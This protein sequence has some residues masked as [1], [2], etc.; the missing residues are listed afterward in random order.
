LLLAGIAAAFATTPGR[1]GGTGHDSEAGASLSAPVWWHRA[2]QTR[3]DAL[4]YWTRARMARAAPRSLTVAGPRRP[5]GPGGVDRGRAKTIPPT[6]PQPTSSVGNHALGRL[7]LAARDLISFTAYFWS[8]PEDRPPASTSGKILAKDQSG[9]YLCSGTVVT[10]A[11]RSLVWTAG[12]CLYTKQ[13]G[14]AK[15]VLFM[16]GYGGDRA[17]FGTWS[18]RGIAVTPRWRKSEAP[19]YDLGAVV[20]RRLK[21]SRIEGR[22]GGQGIAFSLKAKQRWAAFGYPAAPPFDGERLRVCQ[23]TTG[24]RA[25]PDNRPGPRTIA[26]GCDMNQGASG[27]GWE[28][29][30][31]GHTGYVNSLSSYGLQGE[32]DVIYG[33]Y[34]GNAAEALYKYAS[35]R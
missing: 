12:H 17:P 8:G 30:F 18:A 2:A 3:A 16:P 1:A 24:W 22:V 14:W 11:N 13:G 4:G 15:Y 23:S 21:G 32:R 6:A 20:M 10:S 27:G 9:A 25:D 29:K 26:I 5:R 19:R 7:A 33:P 31:D 35:K 34:Q 28:V